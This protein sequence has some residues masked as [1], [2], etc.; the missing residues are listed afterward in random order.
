MNEKG[1]NCGF[2]EVDTRGEVDKEHNT[3]SE[4]DKLVPGCTPAR[5]FVVRPEKDQKGLQEKTAIISSTDSF[6]P[7]RSQSR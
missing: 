4:N 1:L 6:R 2:I 3:F 7:H 5:Y